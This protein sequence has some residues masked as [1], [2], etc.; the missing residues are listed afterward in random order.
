MKGKPRMDTNN[1]FYREEGEERRGQ[2][3][4][5]ALERASHGGSAARYVRIKK[6]ERREK[7][8]VRGHFAVGVR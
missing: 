3:V 2:C 1:F 8:V 7:K 6:S 4:V 5:G